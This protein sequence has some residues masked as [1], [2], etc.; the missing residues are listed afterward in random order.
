[1]KV[2]E[3]EIRQA[4]SDDHDRASLTYVSFPLAA[5]E[6]AAKPTDAEVAAF[7]D[8]EAARDRETSTRRTPRASS[9]SSGPTSATCSP[10]AP[11]TA[12]RRR[13]LRRAQPRSRPP[14]PGSPG[15]R[16][17]RRSPRE[18]SDDATRRSKGGDLGFISPELVDAAFAEAAFKLAAGQVS[19]PVRTASGWHLVQADRGGGGAHDPARRRQA[20]A[21]PRAAH[22]GE[23]ARARD[24]ARPGRPRRREGRPRALRPLPR[25][26]PAQARRPAARRRRHHQLPR[27]PTPPSP[28]SARPPGSARTPSPSAA[29]QALPRVYEAAGRARGRGGEDPRAARPDPVRDPARRSRPSGSRGSA[30]RPCCKTWTSGPREAGARSPGTRPTW[31]ASAPS[32]RRAGSAATGRA[33]EAAPRPR[34]PPRHVTS[35]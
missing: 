20:R 4:W 24:G 2:S 33:G 34:A 6:A 16:S 17:S 27:A 15:A 23:G 12:G 11:E 3:A 13:R 5:A 21:R 28:A 22:E 29:G 14:P 1:M 8:R 35:P 7:A 32:R 19:P 9:R 26:G 31:T 10:G 18:V 25:E 30:R